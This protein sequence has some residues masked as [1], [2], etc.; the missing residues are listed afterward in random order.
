LDAAADP[1]AAAARPEPAPAHLHV[2]LRN[3]CLMVLA[4]SAGAFMLRWASAV[5]IPLLLGLMLSYAMS[6]IVGRLQRWHVPRA[7]SAGAL[8]LGVL[9]GLGALTVSLAD[10]AAALIESLPDSAQKLGRALRTS[11]GPAEGPIEKVQRAA[12]S[13][14]QAAEDSAAAAPRSSKGVT[15]V[16]IERPRVNVKDYLW[17]STPGLVGLLGEVTV[18]GFMAFFLVVSGD[19][20]RRKMVRIAGPA[21]SRKKITL[22]VLDEITSQIQRYLLV[23]VAISVIVGVATWLVLLAIGVERA[24]VWG[25]AA[26]LANLV[27]YLGSVVITV[28]VTLA[29]FLQFDVLDTALVTGLATLAIHVVSGN[30]L[31]PWLTSRSSRLN[32]VAVFA[33]VLAWGW[34]WGIWGLLLGAPLLMVT[35]AVCDSIDALKPMGELLGA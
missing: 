8:M 28:G 33:G 29:A 15:R 10:D 7:I 14:E 27:P 20:F 11:R 23:Q 18:V 1:E 34:L 25:V 3:A 19:N 30:L 31:T 5:F 24:A 26:A 35:K 32:P 9:W 13:L 16:Q 21:F 12:A 6:P 4:F 22:Q 2:D 17:S